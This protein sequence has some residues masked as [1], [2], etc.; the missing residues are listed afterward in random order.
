MFEKHWRWWCAGVFALTV[1]LHL[2]PVENYL[3]NDDAWNYVLESQMLLDGEGSAWVSG[4]SYFKRQNLL[5]II[6]SLSFVTRYGLFGLAMPAWHIP[7]IFL[8]ALNALLLILLARRLGLGRFTAIMSGALFG[9]SPLHSHTISWIGG[10]FDLFC[11]A[12]FLGALLAFSHRR[13]ALGLLMTAGA[14]MSK[15]SGTMIGPILALYVLFFE[16]NDG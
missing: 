4:D 13:T 3:D 1:L 9:L 16:K 6:P 14:M 12:F 7:S 15:E 8:H 10:S 5:R 11:G 2:A